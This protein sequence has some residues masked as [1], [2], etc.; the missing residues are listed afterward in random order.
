MSSQ[1][2]CRLLSFPGPRGRQY[3]GLGRGVTRE[4]NEPTIL[5]LLP[6]PSA[7]FPTKKKKDAWEPGYQMSTV[8]RVI[9]HLQTSAERN[10]VSLHVNPSKTTIATVKWLPHS[11]KPDAIFSYFCI[12]LFHFIKK[13]QNSTFVVR[14]TGN[15]SHLIPVLT[16]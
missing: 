2:P 4:K 7:K 3:G 14:Y 8:Q 16:R 12:L 15:N 10:W 5:L 1:V 11:N 9:H 6:M 13:L